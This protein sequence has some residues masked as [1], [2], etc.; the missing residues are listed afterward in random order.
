MPA[1]DLFHDQIIHALIKDGWT[2]TDDPL[3]IRWGKRH[4]YVDLGAE[5]LLA[6]EKAERKIAVEIKGF[7]GKSD[8]QSLEQALGQFVL[9]GKVLAEVD[10]ERILFLAIHE[11]AF[12]AVFDDAM[13]QLLLRRNL[14]RLIVF[15][16]DKEEILRW[17]P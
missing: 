6:A 9:Y 10:P 17:I 3:H 8:V 15:D 16:P 5:R 12:L 1:R 4:F 11:R 7:V 2:I 13:D 14:L